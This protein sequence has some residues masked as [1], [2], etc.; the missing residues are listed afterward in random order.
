MAASLSGF[1]VLGVGVA[2]T[3]ELLYFH[4]VGVFLFVFGGL[5]IALLAGYASQCNFRAHEVSPFLGS[6]NQNY[7]IKKARSRLIWQSVP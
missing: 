4:A 5:V 3:A 7:N 1:A 2:E 6:W